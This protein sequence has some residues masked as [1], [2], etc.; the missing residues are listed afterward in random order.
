MTVFADILKRYGEASVIHSGQTETDVS[1]FIQ[2]MVTN[3]TEQTWREMTEL[4][5]CDT[6]RYV[7]F[8]P[9]DAVCRVGDVL[10]SNGTEYEFLKAE[11]FRVHGK[12][13]HIEAVLK[14]REDVYDG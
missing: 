9:A 2:P 6:S 8:L 11:P 10:T 4:G 1:V 3:R 13:S 5:E 7:A 14:K 12:L